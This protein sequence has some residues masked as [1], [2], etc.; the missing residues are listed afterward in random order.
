M[1]YGTRLIYHIASHGSLDD[2]HLLLMDSHYSHTFNYGFMDMMRQNN[3][4]VLVVKLIDFW[5]SNYESL[6]V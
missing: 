6:N 3:I 1:E 4:T 2:N 5:F